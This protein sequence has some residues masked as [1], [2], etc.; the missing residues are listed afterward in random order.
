MCCSTIGSKLPTVM[1]RERR[2]QGQTD[3]PAEQSSAGQGP[4]LSAAHAHPRGPG[5][6]DCAAP[7]GP[8]FLDRLKSRRRAVLPAKYRMRRSAEFGLAVRSGVRAPQPS[9]VVHIRRHAIQNMDATPLIGLIV[10]KS[11]GGSVDRH[12]VAR[13]LRHAARSIVDELDP[14]DRVVIRA[15]PSSRTAPSLMLEQQLR[16]GVRRAHL[17]IERKR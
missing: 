10:A 2:G 16:A 8:R 13:R 14:A 9:V 15:L 1:R 6:S 3:I 4:W 7:Q 17:L 5:D 12:R 11:V